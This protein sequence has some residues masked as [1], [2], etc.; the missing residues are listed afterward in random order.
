MY[1]NFEILKFSCLKRCRS[2]HCTH[3]HSPNH[4]S[5]VRSWFRYCHGG[6]SISSGIQAIQKFYGSDYVKSAELLAGAHCP[7]DQVRGGGHVG[8]GEGL[9]KTVNIVKYHDLRGYT[10]VIDSKAFFH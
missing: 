4:K 8:A 1:V 3:C 5:F 7:K 2:N 9:R 10:E 6:R